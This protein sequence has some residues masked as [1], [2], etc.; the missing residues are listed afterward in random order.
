VSERLAG[1]PVKPEFRPT[2]PE[3]L[4]PRMRAW[5][6]T[7]AIVGGLVAVALVALL[8]LLGRGSG[9]A[10]QTVVV[11]EPVA[12]NLVYDADRLDRITPPP[13]GASLEL[14][15]N[16][17]DPDPETFTVRP[18]TLPAYRGDPA[19]VEPIVASGLIAQMRRTYPGFILRSE[20][21][22][23]INSQPGYQIQFQTRVGG[24]TAYGRRTILFPD[25]PAVREGADI[26]VLSVRSPT[27]PNV[28]AVGSNGP[29]KQPYRSFRFGTERP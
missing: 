11:R 6:R 13:A 20:S 10:T 14:R 1:P 28:D 9:A 25:E 29:M 22:T 17:S 4:G 3:L 12:F 7:G 21:R 27:I 24:R 26:T 2:L 23:R 15:T 16:A 8:V 5:G 19:G 18:I